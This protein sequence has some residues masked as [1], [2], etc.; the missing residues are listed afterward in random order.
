MLGRGIDQIL[1]RSNDPR[2][3]EPYLR[4]A[5][6]YVELAEEANGPIPREVECDYVWGDLLPMLEQVK[7]E[8]SIVNLETA[9]TRSDEYWPGKGINYRLHPDNVD[10]LKRLEIDCCVLANNH[11]LDWGYPGLEETLRTLEHAGIAAV[12]AGRNREAAAAPGLIEIDGR[13]R[14]LVFALGSTS[15]GIPRAWSAAE[16]RSGLWLLE[17]PQGAGVE[18]IARRVQAH[19]RSGDIVV[20]SLHWGGNWGYDI[21]AEQRR[22]AHALIDE[23]GADLV[24]GHS[25]HHPKGI[26]VHNGRLILYGCGDFVNDYEGIRGHEAYRGDL[27]LAYL[28]RLDART[29]ELL[30]LVMWPFQ[31]RRFQL[32]RASR[33]DAGW[34]AQV[35]DRESRQLGAG[36]DLRDGVL[37]LRRG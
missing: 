35:L 15:S 8:A 12:G 17:G 1:Q 3:Y 16:R 19:R 7:P 13:R 14:V 21:P 23:A 30:E 20:I 37:R 5:T 2:I 27:S 36:V 4:S 33:P 31:I 34:L 25:S 18:E 22:L 24:H 32:Q 29:G 6:G 11:V 26:E 28:P 9:M 10:C